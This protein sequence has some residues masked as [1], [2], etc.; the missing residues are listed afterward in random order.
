MTKSTGF[1]P[2]EDTQDDYL[3]KTLSH[4]VTQ[5]GIAISVLLIN[6]KALKKPSKTCSI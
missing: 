3:G 1:C 5:S 4:L 2:V 6:Q